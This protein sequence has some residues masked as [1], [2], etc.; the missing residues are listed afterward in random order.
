MDF[1]HAFRRVFLLCIPQPIEPER[2]IFDN[3][4]DFAPKQTVSGGVSVFSRTVLL[5][6]T[7]VENFEA[8][9]RASLDSVFA[10]LAMS[11]RL[12]LRS[13]KGC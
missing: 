7:S 12:E 3:S 1:V 4:L 13:P 11:G 9:N 5:W 10:E 6:G 8:K 2:G